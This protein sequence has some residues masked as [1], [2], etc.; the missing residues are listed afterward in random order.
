MN[1]IKLAIVCLASGLGVAFVV[2]IMMYFQTLE[3]DM[4]VC[5]LTYSHDT[6]FSALNR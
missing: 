4:R 6:C 5:Q 3:R 2:M 1:E